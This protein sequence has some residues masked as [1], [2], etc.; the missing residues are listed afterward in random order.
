MAFLMARCNLAISFLD[1][2][3]DETSTGSVE[4][5]LLSSAVM[6]VSSLTTASLAS[7]A[8]ALIYRPVDRKALTCVREIYLIILYW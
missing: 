1:I 4:A 8:S 3:D 5:A 7:L 6:A 2:S